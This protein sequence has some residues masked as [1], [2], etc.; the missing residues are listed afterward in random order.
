MSTKRI[1][2]ALAGAVDQAF[3]LPVRL[4]AR[5]YRTRFARTGTNFSFD[6]LSVYSYQNISVSEHGNLGYRPVLI[7]S[8]SRI[9]IG[10]HVMF[11]PQ[12]TIRGGNHRIDLLGRYMCAVRDYEKRPEDDPGVVI[13]DDVW[14]GTRAIILAGVTIGRGSVVAAGAVVTKSVPPYAIVGGNPA[15]ILR[16]RWSEGEIVEHERRLVEQAPR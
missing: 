10:S 13:E 15:R 16:L 9:V 11:V 12:V 3:A 7:A 1:R 8:R 4:L 14:V 2:S 5:L 6:P